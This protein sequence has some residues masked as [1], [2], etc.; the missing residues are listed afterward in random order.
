M[1]A[2]LCAAVCAACATTVQPKFP[3]DVAAGVRAGMRRME[4]DTFIIYYPAARRDEAI[5]FAGRAEGCGTALRSHAALRNHVFREKPIL[6]VPDVPFNNAYVS[7]PALG[8]EDHAVVPLQ[9]T[10]DFSTELGFPPDPGYVAC[11]EL[12]H[13]TQ[14]MQ[15]AGIWYAIDLLFGAVT[16]PQVGLDSWFWEGLAVHYETALQPDAGRPRWPIF[17]GM[18]A[19]AYAGGR[20]TTS[21]LSE[22]N[23]EP[24]PGGNYLVGGMFVDFLARTYGE[25]ALWRVITAQASSTWIAL[26]VNDAFV[27]ATGKSIGA[28]FDE[29]RADTA[30]R[31]PVRA[32]PPDQRHV[33]GGGEGDDARFARGQGGTEAVVGS[34]VDV[35]VHL[36]VFG[37]DGARRARVALVDVVPPRTL[38]TADP[39]LTSGLSITR[40]GD[41]YLTMIDQ[42]ATYQVARLVRWRASRP[43]SIE[44]VASGLGPGACVSPDGAT[45]YY[46][47]VDGDR[48]SLGAYD[49]ATGARRVVRDM[50][51]GQYVLAAQPSPDGRRLIASVWDG[52]FSLHVLDAATGELAAR[53]DGAG[54]TPVYDGAFVD[55][56]RVVYLA[57][58]VG[59][60]QAAVRDVATGATRIATD[61]PYA[62]LDARA[63]G[64]ALRFLSR[65]GWEWDLDEVALPA[66]GGDVI[67]PIETPPPPP[68]TATPHVLS[69][70][71]YSELD[72]LFAPT[73][74][75]LTLY[76]PATG[77]TIYGLALAGGDRLGHDRW[78]VAGYLEP[79]TRELSGQA[80]FVN[81][82][83]AP[84]YLSLAADWLR[85]TETDKDS[86][87]DDVRVH[88]E[89]RDAQ[90]AF[91]RTW[92]GS[93]SAF[94]RGVSSE[95]H[96]RATGFAPDD[97]RLVGPGVSLAYSGFD[98][99]PY[100]GLRRGGALAIDATWYPAAA[101]QPARIRLVRRVRAGRERRGDPRAHVV[102]S[103]E[104]DERRV[105]DRQIEERGATRARGVGGGRHVVR[106]E[107]GGRARREPHDQNPG[108]T[109]TSCVH[110]SSSASRR[111]TWYVTVSG[112]RNSK[113]CAETATP[114]AA[115]SRRPPGDPST[116][117]A[118]N[119]SRS[120][121]RRKLAGNR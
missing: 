44:E 15:I 8:E 110:A 77:T 84:W 68:A 48:W 95:L 36:D 61:A 88:R 93:W 41:V 43:G 119:T 98:A 34:D 16:T 7:P 109:P 12:T 27:A 71:P 39:I 19:A 14:Q 121:S 13:D 86:L 30:A 10:F 69:D 53:I 106:I 38:V 118:A 3:D 85:W 74:H 97:V 57:E 67:A 78:A 103:R 40:A 60:F 94:A 70:A 108:P 113:T 55:D 117:P 11:H 102:V 33:R 96:D 91:G 120:N 99:T 75:A 59:R 58:L 54:D 45:Y 73:L 80:S 31:F 4:T 5:R 100:A 52:R 32:T 6:V 28:L 87:G 92:R 76:Q 116:P 90:A 72:H 37:P 112:M 49:V 66:P 1:R 89:E 42:G 23:R 105:G 51:P 81:A 82:R 20:L 65:R 17:T 2:I 107:I 18:F 24:P 79:D 101:A 114:A 111:A 63:A 29:F 35:P 47:I 25:D 115:C 62:V 104:P 56:A 46:L 9:A 26:A 21:D 83:L 64:G 22:L 50:P